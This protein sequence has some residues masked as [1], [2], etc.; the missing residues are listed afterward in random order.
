M[1]CITENV[2]VKNKRAGDHEMKIAIDDE[3]KGDRNRYRD[4]N[5]MKIE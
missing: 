4:R 2:S 5:G 3:M 1:A